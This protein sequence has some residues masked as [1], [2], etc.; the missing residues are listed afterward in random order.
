MRSHVLWRIVEIE[1]GRDHE[2]DSAK[3][4]KYMTAAQQ[5]G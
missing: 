2:D 4:T 5:H 1:A 3:K